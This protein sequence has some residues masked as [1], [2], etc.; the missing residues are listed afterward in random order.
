[1][2]R[3]KWKEQSYKPP[4]GLV[5]LVSWFGWLGII[6]YSGILSLWNILKYVINQTHAKC[7]F[8]ATSSNR[9]NYIPPRLPKSPAPAP[10]S[11]GG[12]FL[13]LCLRAQVQKAPNTFYPRNS[14]HENHY[15]KP[16]YLRRMKT[17]VYD[18]VKAEK[19]IAAQVLHTQCAHEFWALQSAGGSYFFPLVRRRA[20][21]HKDQASA[22]SAFRAW[23]SACMGSRNLGVIKLLAARRV[24]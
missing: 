21:S 20:N 23:S 7:T 19:Q 6:G 10:A 13:A 5:G 15:L 4:N 16:F 8:L 2:S 1:M 11:F 3:F 18:C 17:F 9:S 22:A 14:N 12:D 24:N